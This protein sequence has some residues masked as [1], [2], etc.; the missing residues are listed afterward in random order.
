[1]ESESHFDCSCVSRNVVV[2]VMKAQMLFLHL[3]YKSVRT[4]LQIH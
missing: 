1:M 4:N 3:L 2:V